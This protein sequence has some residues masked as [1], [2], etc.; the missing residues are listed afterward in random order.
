MCDS[1]GIG[2]FA[3]GWLARRLVRG[4]TRTRVARKS[5]AFTGL[6]IAA[7]LLLLVSRVDDPIMAIAT[8]GLA[9]F[10]NDLAIP[11]AWAACMDVGGKYAGSLSGSMNMMG[12]LGGAVGALVVAQILKFTDNNWTICFWVAAGIYLIGAACWLFIDPVTPLDGSLEREEF[13]AS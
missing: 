6:T 10:A 8:L 7:C 13:A 11:N 3:G 9:S 4:G 12:N 5:V 1:G 2:C